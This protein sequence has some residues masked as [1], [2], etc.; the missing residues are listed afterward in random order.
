MKFR[1]TFILVFFSLFLATNF[2]YAAVIINE[3]KIKPTGESFIELYNSNNTAQ[4]LTGWSIKRKTASGTEY[5]LV[6]A[7]RMQGKSILA[8]SYF[9]LANE[10][11]YTGIITPDVAWATSYNLVN[12]NAIVL[13]NGAEIISKVGWG[14]VNINDCDVVCASN[15]DEGKSIQK[16]SNGWVVLNPTPKMINED[17]T[18]VVSPP[19]SSGGGGG[20]S[21]PATTIEIKPKIIEVPKI[22]TKI[23]AKDLAFIGIPLELEAST[24]GYSGE[25]RN[26]GKYYWNFGDG[27]SKEINAN[28][29]QKFTHTYY[30]EGDYEITLEYYSN[31]YSE[32]SDTINKFFV[33]VI[34]AT[35]FISKIG[36]EK[37]FFIELSNDS[38]YD[39]DVSRWKITSSNKTFVLPKNTSIGTKSKMIL[40]PKIT[41]FT[42][43]DKDSLK[44]STSTGE[45]A[46]SYNP[47]P[48]INTSV[49]EM[50]KVIPETPIEREKQETLT[51][52][53]SDNNQIEKGILPTTPDQDLQNGNKNSALDLAASPMPSDTKE[54]NTNKSYFFFGSFVVLLLV[55]GGVVYY[56]R[57]RKNVSK[58][59]DD[60]KII[61][62]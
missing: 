52:T 2:A 10:G 19:I 39:I 62:E 28:Q 49:A 43:E 1:I 35:V 27:D 46:F 15:P 44:L 16:T 21:I 5:P 34:P 29:N 11:N 48:Q 40:S 26:Y 30:Y 37:D 51:N 24:I 7:S 61:D 9:L 58:V 4:D 13:Y 42:I 50:G 60:F 25:I 20:P 32:V 36:D 38:L 41:N 22:K 47:S 23:I 8:N 12:D 31:Y 17:N 55:S 56:I 59:G 53:N 3:V 18:I 14:E 33:K 54:E 6:S 57:Q 45:I